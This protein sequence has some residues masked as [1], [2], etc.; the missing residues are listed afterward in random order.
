[1]ID[2]IKFIFQARESVSGGTKV[3]GS[4]LWPLLGTHLRVTFSAL[5]VA[6]A[7]AVPLGVLLGHL[8]R[9]QVIASSIADIGRALPTYAVVVFS[10]AYIGYN[11]SN[12]VFAL[13]LLAIPPIFVN[14]YVGVRQVDRETVD[15][16]TGLGLTGSQVVRQVELPLAVPLI[17]G[18]IRTSAVNVAATATLGPFVGVATLGEPIINNNV[19]GDAGRLGGSILVALLA[20]GFELGFAVLQRTVT[21][22]GL[23]TTNRRKHPMKLR[24]ITSALLAA[25]ALTIV[26]CGSDNNKSSSSTGGGTTTQASNSKLI[27]KDPANDAKP[28][29]TLGSKNFTEQFVAGEIYAQALEAA[30]FKVKRQFNLGSEVIAHKA[31][32]SDKIDAYPEYT[33]TALTSFF[34]VKP[35]DVPRDAQQAYQEAK[36]D[37][38]KEGIVALAPTPFESSNGFA[39]TQATASKDGLKTLSDLS[40]TA[41]SMTIS[42]GPE[43]KQREDCLLGLEKV[44]GLKFKKFLSIDLAK[45]HEVIVK[46]QSDVGLVFTTDGQIKTD[47]LVLLA[48]DKNLFPP[49]NLT[50]TMTQKTADELGTE[51]QG[52]IEKVQKGLT[53]PV[54]QELNSRVDIDKEKYADVATEYLKESGYVS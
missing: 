33:G 7:V 40:M 10:A 15:A 53:T 2:A 37:Y 8:G 49:Y 11:V 3:G 17:F 47:K 51:G 42:G 26:A 21:P 34:K 36:A 32:T 52:V 23:K 4:E 38:A 45:R 28:T 24:V 25:L 9:G 54:M 41:S 46:G 48:D 50:F 1:V 18:G 22:S 39:V 5:V 19:Y 12:L 13:V 44:Y 30:G 29:I 14:T 27:Q 43:C 16:A 31:L 20:F 35:A 6:I